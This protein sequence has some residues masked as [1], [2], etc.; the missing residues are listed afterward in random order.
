MRVVLKS[1]ILA[2]VLAFAATDANAWYC[3][4]T[5]KNGATGTGFN[6]FQS[7]SQKTALKQCRL[8]SKGKKCKIT[9]CW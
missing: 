7:E 6:F 9:S 5:A 2:F 3:T 4:A 1:S 8:Q